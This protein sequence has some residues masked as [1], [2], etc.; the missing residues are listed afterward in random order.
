MVVFKF[1]CFCL[2]PSDNMAVT[3]IS[4][5][6]LQRM[7]TQ[8][9]DLREA[10]YAL[11]EEGNRSKNGMFSVFVLGLH[12]CYDLAFFCFSYRIEGSQRKI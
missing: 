5:E 10:N 3:G 6:E 4:N 11:M 12:F 1:P 7:Q 9:L 8:L 2:R